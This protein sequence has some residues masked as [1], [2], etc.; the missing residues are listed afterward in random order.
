MTGVPFSFH[1]GTMARQ[2]L[3]SVSECVRRGYNLR[4]TCN[5][6]GRAVEANAVELKL[7]LY[8]RHASQLLDVL[9][10][11]AK[12]TA[13]GHRGAAIVPCEINF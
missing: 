12:C 4:F 9:E 13:C 6:C 1:P 11:K 7:D 10:D 3:D 5:G 8:R 2:K